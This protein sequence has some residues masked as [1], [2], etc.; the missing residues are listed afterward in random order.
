MAVKFSFPADY[1]KNL[2]INSQDVE[3]LHTHL[4]EIETPLTAH[5]LVPVFIANRI[6]SELE[7]RNRERTSDSKTYLPREKY[8]AGDQLVF[9]ALD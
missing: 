2:E 5:D 9:P 4:F 8:G 7:S 6:K 1:W 3:L